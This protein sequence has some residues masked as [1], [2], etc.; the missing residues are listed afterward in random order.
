MAK[1]RIKIPTPTWEHEQTGIAQ[2]LEANRWQ[3]WATVG[4]VLLVF[5]SLGVIGWAYLADYIGDQQRPGSLGLRVAE[6][7]LTVSDYTKRAVLKAEELS[8]VS[9]SI[10][11]PVLSQD[12]IEEMILLQFADEQSVTATD[13]EIQEDIATRLGIAVDDSNFDARLQEELARN[14]LTEEQFRDISRAKILGTKVTAGFQADIPDTLP[15]VN[16]R[17][18]QVE[19]Q[20]AADGLLAQL[21]EGAEFGSLAAEHSLDQTSG[22]A[23]GEKGWAAEGVLDEDAEAVLFALEP[24]EVTTFVGPNS[25]F[26][27]YEVTEKSNA[28]AV[29]IDNSIR[30]GVLAYSEWLAAKALDINIENEMEPPAAGGDPDKIR[31]VVDHA[32]LN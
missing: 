20:E 9:A 27:V 18:I 24:G 5:A 1:R 28:R 13:D 21:S 16:Y 25:S 7:E 31:Y 23:G 6:Q 22:Q 2:K 19:D 11:I 26:F 4:I 3:L 12:L 15:S 17:E 14:G 30:L 32:N 29:S 8:S 10:V